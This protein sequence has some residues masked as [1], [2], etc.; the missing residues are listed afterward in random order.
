MIEASPEYKAMIEA[1]E[2]HDMSELDEFIRVIKDLSRE[3]TY[4]EGGKAYTPDSNRWSWARNMNCKY[5]TLR[6]DMRDG[7]FH[8]CCDKLGRISLDQLKWQY[9][10]E[11]EEDHA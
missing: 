7:G 3:P 10:A 5:I 9:R 6:F 11:S 4:T 8:L 1:N 2:W